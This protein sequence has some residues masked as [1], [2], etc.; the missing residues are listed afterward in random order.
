MKVAALLLA[1]GES[2][3]LGRAKQLLAYRG[4]P[5][6]RAL[7]IE[8]CASRC[9]A[10]GV[11]IQ[12]RNAAIEACLDGLP[13][14]VIANPE[15][16]EGMASSIRRGA[17]WADC[18][19]FDAV[20]LL[21]CDQPA[22]TA[23]HVDALLDASRSGARVVASRYGRA[24]GVPALFTRGVM[25]SLL[26]LRGDVGARS[27]IRVEAHVTAVDWPEGAFDVDTAADAARLPP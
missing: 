13:V 25:P 16:P 26:R 12:E 4:R 9:D 10:V 18:A 1:A 21:V 17:R 15:W 22:L 20:V 6:L 3:R 14:H 23:A 7:A 8:A 11:V 5:L 27:L 19:G 2:R 24:L